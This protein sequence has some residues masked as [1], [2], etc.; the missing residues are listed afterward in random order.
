MQEVA[1]IS[2]R[3]EGEL[4]LHAA[5]RAV[6]SPG[7][8]FMLAVQIFLMFVLQWRAPTDAAPLV[9]TLALFLTAATLLLFFYLQAGA[10][11]ALTLRREALTVAETIRAGKT[12]FSSFVWLTLKAGLLFALII[13]VLVLVLLFLTGL[14]F[15]SLTQ[16]LTAYF[17][18]AT[19]VLAF[20]F[21]YW[22]PY[23][24]VH[25]DFHLLSSLKAGLRIAWE[26]LPHSAFL[27]MMV[28]VP[29][30]ATGFIPAESPLLVD[31]LASILTGI[32]GWISYIYSVDILR[33]RQTIVPDENPV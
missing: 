14:D 24:F 22:L 26:R 18:P 23:A 21:V 32:M 13:N 3:T 33:Q 7:I 19:G 16:G 15:K 11:H 17:G 25:R 4:R 2:S 30:L 6:L 27:V 29:A 9:S 31:V 10:F 28:L 5:I 8:W 20:V 1:R 12:V